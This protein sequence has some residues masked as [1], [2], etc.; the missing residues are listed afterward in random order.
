[1]LLY[2]LPRAYKSRQTTKQQR[3][4]LPC[5]LILT[6]K[7]WNSALPI[8]RN[9]FLVPR[10]WNNFM[11][12]YFIH[13]VCA[14]ILYD[15]L[16]QLLKSWNWPSIFSTYFVTL[17]I[18]KLKRF[19]NVRSLISISTEQYVKQWYFDNYKINNI[20]FWNETILLLLQF[21]SKNVN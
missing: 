7:P 9:R 21:E 3:S 1:M 4:I 11:F 10:R 20:E 19:W 17:S 14:T 8:P 15:E 13:R 5:D 6:E 18:I 12:I 2:F 16:K